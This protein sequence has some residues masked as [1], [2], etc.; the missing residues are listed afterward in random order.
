ME[1]RYRKEERKNEEV[2]EGTVEKLQGGEEKE[3]AEAEEE[4]EEEAEEEGSGFWRGKMC[5]EAFGK[6]SCQN[7]SAVFENFPPR[8]YEIRIV[9]VSYIS[10]TQN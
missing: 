1:G 3:V 9:H 7:I 5:N 10:N 2:G 6:P 4:E 8:G